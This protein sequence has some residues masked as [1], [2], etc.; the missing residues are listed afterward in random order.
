[1]SQINSAKD[2]VISVIGFNSPF[3]SEINNFLKLEN[4]KFRESTLIVD[5]DPQKYLKPKGQRFLNKATLVYCN[6]AFQ[7]I[8]NRQLETKIQSNPERVGLYDGTELSNLEDCFVFD[9]TAKNIGPDRVSPMKAPSTIANAAASQMAIQAGIKGPNFSVCAGMAGSLQALD[10]ACL[11][12]KQE[13]IEYSIV[14]STEVRNDYQ[15]SI[16]LG[17]NLG[18]MESSPEIGISFLLERRE[19]LM[20]DKRIPLASIKTIFSET[21]TAEN[22][23]LESFLIDTI[24][25]LNSNSPF[26]L[27]IISGGVHMINQKELE[28]IFEE[29][30]LHMKVL[31]PENQIGAMDNA[32]GM[33]GIAKGISIFHEESKEKTEFEHILVISIDHSSTIIYTVIK[34]EN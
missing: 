17:L 6:V 18:E 12:L 15:Q 24:I 23:S 19:S 9:L 4:E 10:I 8:H 27:I 1:M 21:F 32:G 33:L 11:H 28:N 26:D 13:F 30:D 3:G 20:S 34:K 25:K 7:A 29:Q 14:G 5:Y 16:H 22:Q 31:Y 2:I